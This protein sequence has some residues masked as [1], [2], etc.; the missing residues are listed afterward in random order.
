MDKQ[1]QE[2]WQEVL[3]AIEEVGGEPVRAEFAAL[4]EEHA[5]RE[6]TEVTVLGPF[7][8]G[9]SSVLRRLL[10]DADVAVPPWLTVSG[11]RETF[12]LN[13]MDAGELSYTDAPGFAAGNELHSLLA[14][15]ALSLT[16]AF[17]LVVPPNLLTTKREDVA[18]ILSGE[19]FFGEPAGDVVGATIAILAQAD[20]LGPD[21]EDDVELMHEIAARKSAELRAQLEDGGAGD[22]SA[23]EVIAVAADPYEAQ[24]RT[25]QPAR[26]AFDPY[27]SWDGVGMLASSL[28]ELASRKD[29][30]RRQAL[31][32]FA[33]RMGNKTVAAGADVLRDL[34]LAHDDLKGRTTQVRQFATRMHALTE[35]ARG[36]LV[37]RVTAIGSE[38]S[39]QLGGNEDAAQ[40][41]VEE[42]LSSVLER[43]ARRWD[44]EADLLLGEA[45]VDVDLRLTRPS[46]GRTTAFLRSL[47]TPVPAPATDAPNSRV[48][49]VLNDLRGDLQD[50]TRTA[51]EANLRGS[52]QDLARSASKVKHPKAGGATV[53]DLASSAAKLQA[54]MQI[55][56]G[57]LTIVTTLDR[58]RAQQQRDN[59]LRTQREAARDKIQ[60]TAEDLADDVSAAWRGRLDEALAAVRERLGLRPGADVPGLA[61]EIATRRAALTKLETLLASTAVLAT[62]DPA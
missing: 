60:R 35:A 42:Q 8:S 12:E 51:V 6:R 25:P 48:V 53:G 20:T 59:A 32:R 18:R 7:D 34:E 31:L 16:D 21:P 49:R 17:M 33:A 23:L 40:T 9:K 10:V 47:Q 15:D 52:L 14:D 50:V 1:V 26:A 2:H 24:A 22:L 46:A 13:E 41:R 54:A 28:S 37:D 29:H 44:G 62:A 36:D 39:E 56:D 61:Q 58:E 45:E 3:D 38:L 55:A 27:R 30:L 11:R 57:V 5:A 43:W 19:H 4:W